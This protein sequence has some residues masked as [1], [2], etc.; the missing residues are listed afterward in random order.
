MNALLSL[1][2]RTAEQPC[3]SAANDS[4]YWILQSGLESP[5][6]MMAEGGTVLP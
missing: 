5:S 2:Q 1:S 3:V 6:L 4:G